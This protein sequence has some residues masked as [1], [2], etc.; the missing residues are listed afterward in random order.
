MA[1]LS[2][3]V[4]LLMLAS[5][6]IAQSQDKFEIFGGYSYFGGSYTTEGVFPNNPNG[7]NVAP[8][9]YQAVKLSL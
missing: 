7:W 8:A 1:R 6:L 2:S 4:V 3:L 5:S 9:P